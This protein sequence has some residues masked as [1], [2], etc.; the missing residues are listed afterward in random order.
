MEK[1]ECV[2]RYYEAFQEGQGCHE[3]VSPLVVRKLVDSLVPSPRFDLEIAHSVI[4]AP[5]TLL[6][7]EV[8]PWSGRES[9][10]R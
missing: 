6:E 2:Q 8:P 10:V 4:E 1:I 9:L 5:R 7:L 3:F